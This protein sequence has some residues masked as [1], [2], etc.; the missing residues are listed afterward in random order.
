[1][2]GFFNSKVAS[3]GIHLQFLPFVVLPLPFSILQLCFMMIM[4]IWIQGLVSKKSRRNFASSVLSANKKI[5]SAKLSLWSEIAP[6]IP[7]ASLS[8]NNI[9]KSIMFACATC[10]IQ[11]QMQVCARKVRETATFIAVIW[12]HLSNG[13]KL[14]LPQK[15]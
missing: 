1:M 11:L 8:V 5:T 9:C 6:V 3:E 12:G 2:C 4:G 13:S 15:H 14:S 7:P 10:R